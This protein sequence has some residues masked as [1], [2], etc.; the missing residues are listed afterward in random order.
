MENNNTERKTYTSPKLTNH[1]NIQALTQ[2]TTT[3]GTRWDW[4][5]C[6]FKTK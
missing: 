6:R 4:T 5:Y 3:N 1:G 2:A